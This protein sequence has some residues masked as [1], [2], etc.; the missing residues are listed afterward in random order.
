M[1]CVIKYDYNN[2]LKLKPHEQ[3]LWCK[4][5][6]TGFDWVF[7][8]AQHAALADKPICNSCKANIIKALKE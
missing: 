8:G 6:R 3:V 1:S 2:G 4:K 7:N 5:D